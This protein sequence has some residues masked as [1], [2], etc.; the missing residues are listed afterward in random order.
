M[1]ARR[2]DKDLLTEG[3]VVVDRIKLESLGDHSTRSTSTGDYSMGFSKRSHAQ[4]S[5]HINISFLSNDGLY[6][7]FILGT[8]S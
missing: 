3:Y 8:S 2:S 4:F 7:L 1:I 6:G 5:Y